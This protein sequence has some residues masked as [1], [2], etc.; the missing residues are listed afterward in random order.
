MT[1]TAVTR[2]TSDDAATLRWL[3]DTYEQVQRERIRTD[4]RFLAFEQERDATQMPAALRRVMSDL[5][6]QETALSA[7]MGE[8]IARHPA[9]PWLSRIKGIGPILGGKVLGLI[10]DIAPSETVSKLWR[11]AGLAVIDGK[12]ERLK[13]PSCPQCGAR[14]RRKA[15]ACP[16]SGETTEIKGEK[17]HYN[18]RL[19]TALYL[20]GTAWIKLPECYYER[21][22][23]QARHRYESRPHACPTHPKPKPACPTCWVPGRIH[24]TALRVAEKLFLA[25]LWQVWRE[26][27]ELPIRARYVEEKLGHGPVSDPWE[28]AEKPE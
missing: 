16:V 2:W 14:G 11:F 6:G 5:E 22:Y 12:R 9:W 3:V 23:R 1:T 7:D 15:H 13:S 28:A 20:C 4:N 17:A 10:G 27:V 24:L 18:V 19:K 21:V 25:H 8:L 26:A